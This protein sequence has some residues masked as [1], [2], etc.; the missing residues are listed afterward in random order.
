MKI[1]FLLF[2]FFYL[3]IN[4]KGQNVGIGTTAPNA[5]LH[6]NGSFRI[7]NGSQGQ[8]KVL[9][10]DAAGLATWKSASDTG[11]YYPAV[12]ICC[13]TWMTKN[14]DVSYYS[15]G[16]PIPQVTDAAAWAA[17][18]TGAWCYPNNNADS[19]AVYGK[20]YNWYAVNDSRGLAPRGW[21]VPTTFEF[22]T[23]YTCLGGDAGNAGLLMKEKGVTHWQSAGNDATNLSGFTALGAGYRSD[24]GV[25]V[26][27]TYASFWTASESGSTTIQAIER[28]LFYSGYILL[29][30]N[31]F[32]NQ[33]SSIRCVKD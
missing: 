27:R 12:G 30:R 2:A 33:G 14:L 8:G 15:N 9:T 20:L 26:F 10:S 17:L 32:K 28:Y 25:F 16:D 23:L 7:T 21:H 29:G 4:V 11:A 1:V 24:G 5:K 3:V 22:A 19:G 18:T 13:A 31:S 6:V